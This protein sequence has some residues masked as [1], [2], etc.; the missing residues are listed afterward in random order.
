MS[1][2]YDEEEWEPNE[3][4]LEEMEGENSTKVDFQKNML[5]I[6]FNMENV[7]RGIISQVVAQIQGTLKESVMSEIKK[8]IVSGIKDELK[9][10]THEI[11]RDII[12]EIYATE[13]IQVGSG[14]K[15]P[16]KEYTMKEYVIEQAKNAIT[17][18]SVGKGYNDSFDKWFKEKCVDAD[19]KSI[20]TKA[21]EET[22]R[23]INKEVKEVFDSATREMLS[24][25][26]LNILM[27][28]DT[29]KKIESNIACIATK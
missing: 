21:V 25:E 16:V 13:K 6:N 7:A 17:Q 26:V 19:I 22:R 10:H 15:E 5:N 18:N 23:T 4:E 3:E 14:W 9:E 11:M 12:D 24:K 28:N 20:I 8:E 27:A 1:E 29:Y 2:F